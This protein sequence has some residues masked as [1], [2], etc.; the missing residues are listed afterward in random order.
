MDSLSRLSIRLDVLFPSRLESPKGFAISILNNLQLTRWQIWTMEKP[1][2]GK[3]IFSYM[4]VHVQSNRIFHAEL[5]TWR[6]KRVLELKLM[7][8]KSSSY[9]ISHTFSVH[10]TSSEYM[11][12]IIIIF[13]SICGLYVEKKEW[14]KN[15]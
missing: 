8:W 5:W 10:M 9:T 4:E 3:N 6:W 1:N 11:W 7:E 2:A 13:C 12:K 15:K 14:Y